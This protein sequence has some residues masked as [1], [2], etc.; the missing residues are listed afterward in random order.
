LKRTPCWGNHFCSKGYGV[1][2]AGPN[3]D[4][5]GKDDRYREKKEEQPEQL[6]FID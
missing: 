5:V 1:D 3:T 4:R 6:Q 2:T